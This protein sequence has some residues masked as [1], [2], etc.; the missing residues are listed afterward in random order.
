MNPSTR[1]SMLFLAILSVAYVPGVLSASSVPYVSSISPAV[2]SKEGGTRITVTGA[3]FEDSADLKCKF[4]RVEPETEQVVEKMTCGTY[5]SATEI[6]CDSPSWDEAT[7]PY[8]DKQ[9]DGSTCLTSCANRY[10]WDNTDAH[11]NVLMDNGSP[12]YNAESNQYL[13]AGMGGAMGKYPCPSCANEY[14][15]ENNPNGQ[16]PMGWKNSAGGTQKN[17]I[18]Y[19]HHGSK[20]LRTDSELTITE[21]GQGGFIKIE[22]QFF[23]IARIETCTAAAGCFCDG[24]WSST[25]LATNNSAATTSAIAS[26]PIGPH[27]DSTKN[28]AMYNYDKNPSH[29][30]TLAVPTC[31]TYGAG[32]EPAAFGGSGNSGNF[33]AG[34]KIVLDQP[35]YKQ[36]GTPNEEFFTNEVYVSSKKPCVDCKCAGGCPLTVTVSNNGRTWS[37]GG[38]NGRTWHGSAAKF[39]AKFVIPEVFQIQ[40]PNLEGNRDSSRMFVPATGN[41][42]IRIKGKNF[43][44]GP[45][46]RC[47][48][49]TVRIMTKAEFID[50]ETVECQTP[51]FVARPQD[52]NFNNDPFLD[53]KCSDSFDADGNLREEKMFANDITDA[54]LG[55]S[56][57]LFDTLC[58]NSQQSG[59]A[60]FKVIAGNTNTVNEADYSFAH[61]QVTNNGKF[62]DLSAVVHKRDD[63]AHSYLEGEGSPHRSTCYQLKY[64]TTWADS[65][66]K[67]GHEQ[68]HPCRYAH[69]D[70][71]TGEVFHQGNDVQIKY[72]TCYESLTADGQTGM[73][74]RLTDATDDQFINT[75][76]ALG[77]KFRIPAVSA[78]PLV[79]VDLHLKKAKPSAD[80]GTCADTDDCEASA[81]QATTIEACVSAGGFKGTGQTL[82]CEWFTI[83]NIQSGSDSY[84]VYFTKPPYLLGYYKPD[85]TAGYRTDTH[86]TGATSP[87]FDA[88]YYLT[89]THVSG[90]Q[91]VQW[92]TSQ[93]TADTLA[94][95]ATDDS[96]GA[97][98]FFHEASTN[99]T[100]A[101]S[102]G[103]GFRAQFYTCDGCR[104]EYQ[105]LQDTDR[106]SYQ[107]GKIWDRQNQSDTYLATHPGVTCKSTATQSMGRSYANENYDTAEGLP[108]QNS[109]EDPSGVYADECGTPT[110]REQFA[111]AV[112]PLED[113][114]VTKMRTKMAAAYAGASATH[115]GRSATGDF[116]SA[117][118][119]TVSVW[120]TEHGKLGEHVCHSFTGTTQVSTSGWQNHYVAPAGA[121][122]GAASFGHDGTAGTD[123]L[124]GCGANNEDCMHCDANDDGTYEE[125][126]FLGARCN[127]TLTGVWGGCGVHGVC[128]M[129]NVV[130]NGHVLRNHPD[131]T[132]PMTSRCGEDVDCDNSQNLKV[133]HSLRVKQGTNVT[134]G[135]DSQRDVIWEFEHPVVLKKHTTYYVNMA[136]DETISKSD[137]VYWFAG[138]APQSPAADAAGGPGRS[139]FLGAYHR[140]NYIVD[141]QMMFVWD[142]IIDV[143]FDLELMRCVT[144]LPSI[145]SFSTAGAGTGSCYARS[146]P[147]G[148]LEGPTIT[149]K[150]QN[151]FP[152]ANLRVVWLYPDGSM[153]PHSDCTSTRYDYTEMQCQAPQFNPYDGVD[154]TVPGNCEGV[155]VMPTNDGVNYGPQL[156]SPKFVEPYTDCTPARSPSGA[157]DAVPV[158][159]NGTHYNDDVF[160]QQLG[161][162]Q[163]KYC[164]SDIYVSTSGND[165]SGD[166]SYARPFRTIQ[167]GID[168]ANPIDAIT[169]L[170]GVY[171]GTGNRGIRHGGKRI[172]VKS[173][174]TDQSVTSS[175]GAGISRAGQTVI[176]CE[177]YADG[178]VINNN[179]DS[180]SSFAGF[181]DFSEVTTM[182]CE[183][184][185]LYG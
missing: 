17:T 150:G 177:H 148:G 175:C 81:R 170:P 3:A 41:T 42:R 153:G 67:P 40:F 4:S 20:Y 70:A 100:T 33:L 11:A 19:G 9:R 31:G 142:K 61:V 52:S 59:A 185:R 80:A 37:G 160:V 95:P 139:P 29:W 21:I 14:D 57:R 182:N 161:D 56:T 168:A 135:T 176:D 54:R 122:T 22:S 131:G 147:R 7:C 62:Q 149:F 171:T 93:Q 72:S 15:S 66:V 101:I 112:R 88:T 132:G 166:G 48:F 121:S 164:F 129:S 124:L 8:C 172:Y 82:A 94:R 78:G 89:L 84:K 109:A 35:L 123:L 90:P 85:E 71:Q 174:E 16:H 2:G 130:P 110:Y 1:A 167:R 183:N 46:T 73:D 86:P 97:N 39:S 119:A 75:T 77:Q 30:N 173:L 125:L 96:V 38:T 108:R 116:V 169:M 120:V 76:H 13:H 6:V 181:V 141:N 159:I 146:S 60:T 91:T 111:Q 133:Q 26:Y 102:T 115:A 58:T 28:N 179:K 36:G 151:F 23:T 53:N 98:G 118:G 180:M 34:T 27:P 12:Y 127:K 138:T 114:S 136:I 99:T 44:E 45:L 79:A 154:C 126:C 69:Q 128:A 55:S 105:S 104:W 47:Y 103:N 74:Y 64:P 10:P 163:A 145:E 50:S 178:F 43:Q 18:F 155:H 51:S 140:S 92:A 117:D 134:D 107:V 157:C 24:K 106:T 5:K 158:S 184:L 32:D 137:S 49:D 165:Y 113:I 63:G 87:A 162:N 83:Q 152:S 143:K 144:S 68:S 65:A 25:V 156:F